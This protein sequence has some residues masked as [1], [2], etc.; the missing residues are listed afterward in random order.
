MN[1]SP[2]N[3]PCNNNH[4]FGTSNSPWISLV[5]SIGLMQIQYGGGTDGCW[6][7]LDTARAR[8]HVLPWSKL[9]PRVNV[10]FRATGAHLP[11]RVQFVPARLRLPLP[12]NLPFPPGN[13]N[14]LHTGNSNLSLPI[15]VFDFS[16]FAFDDCLARCPRRLAAST[17][18]SKAEGERGRYFIRV[19]RTRG[20]NIGKP[21]SQALWRASNKGRLVIRSNSARG[22]SR[23]YRTSE[24]NGRGASKPAE[25]AIE[26]EQ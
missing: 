12:Y 16:W 11:G 7:V 26:I 19:R 10:Q 1:P 22:R 6:T 15:Y 17:L 25:L 13:V 23:W 24:M 21:Q 14:L 9:A 18:L 5:I 3:Y 8:A 4:N 2:T 20:T